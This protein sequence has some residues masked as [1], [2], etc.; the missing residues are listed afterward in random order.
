M[1]KQN[2]FA[3]DKKLSDISRR[4]FMKFCGVMAVSMGLPIGVAPQIAEAITNPK[5]RPSVIWLNGQECTGCTESY[6][7]RHNLA[8]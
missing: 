7:G 2:H 4:D 8:L 1:K 5:R 6:C 3:L